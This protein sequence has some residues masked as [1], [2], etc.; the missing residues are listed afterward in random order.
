MLANFLL[1]A[2][3]GMYRGLP[4]RG[5]IGLRGKKT[6]IVDALSAYFPVYMTQFEI[7]LTIID[8]EWWNKFVTFI[9]RKS[10]EHV[11]W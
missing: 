6:N 2:V 8:A 11:T 1:D 7:S 10:T 5:E 4:L 9:V 3:H